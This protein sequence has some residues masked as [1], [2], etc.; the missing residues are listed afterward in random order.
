MH[1]LEND[2]LPEA[3]VFSTLVKECSDAVEHNQVL[4]TFNITFNSSMKHLWD[5]HKEIILYHNN[6]YWKRHSA[7]FI[8]SLKSFHYPPLKKI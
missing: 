2:S 6:T 5:F 8:R 4:D 3:D 7:D 1:F